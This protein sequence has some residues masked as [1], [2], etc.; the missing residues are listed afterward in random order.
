MDRIR[1][2]LAIA[3]VAASLT[4][5]LTAHAATVDKT[6]EEAASSEWKKNFEVYFWL[7]R[8]D[9]KTATDEH[10]TLSLK[11]I[12]NSLKWMT[13]IDFGA[14]KG[15]WSIG[16]DA[17]YLHL[18][19]SKERTT[20]NPIG[21]PLELEARVGIRGFI[22]TFGGAY[23]FA[24]ND[25]YEL[26]ALAGARYLYL[27]VPIEFDVNDVQRKKVTLGGHNWDGIIGMRGKTTLNE[28]WYMDYYAD[29]GTGDSKLTYQ[30][31]V[32]FG[33]KFEKLTGTFGFRYLR[34]NFS[35]SSELDNLRVIGPYV[36]AKWFF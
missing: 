35:S 18:S 2:L 8:I 36:G 11:D 27:K 29:L 20:G 5:V 4:V 17:I 33:Y 22:S 31:K 34:W 21:N 13:M 30:A 6:A 32:G 12:I 1:T 23:Q 24:G 10:I 25:S 26:H 28:K 16:A 9:I 15:K 14:Q 3:L 7:P 19:D